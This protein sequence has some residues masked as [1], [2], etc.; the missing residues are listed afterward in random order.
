MIFALPLLY[1]DHTVCHRD[2][3]IVGERGRKQ[4]NENGK[5]NK[6][7]KMR[8]GSASDFGE[9]AMALL[10]E[11]ANKSGGPRL[12]PITSIDALLS[13]EP[14]LR[15]DDSFCRASVRPPAVEGEEG[16]VRVFFF[17]R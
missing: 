7:K 9:K 16:D 12:L 11:E 14:G 3:D 10:E 2:S 17:S 15:P 6:K 4:N 5:R 1:A 13:W 8:P